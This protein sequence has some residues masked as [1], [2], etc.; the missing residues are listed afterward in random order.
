M[1]DHPFFVKE[2]IVLNTA[3]NH[4]N[5]DI[6]RA[7]ALIAHA[8]PVAA[9]I[10]KD[11]ILRGAWMMA[12]GALDA[13]F[14]DAYADLVARTLRAKAIQ[15]AVEIPDRLNKL[16]LPV[17][18]ILHPNDSW[19]WRMAAR[20]LI[21]EEN[22]LSLEQIRKLFNH[23]FHEDRKLMNQETI[24]GWVT[25]ADA[26][27]RLFGVTRTAYNALNAAQKAAARKAALKQ[28]E[29]RYKSIFQRR[30]DCIHNCDRPL[31]APQQVAP[32]MVTK[33]KEDVSFLVAR[34]HQALVAEFPVYLQTL[35]FNAVTRNQVTQ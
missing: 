19:R 30:H 28:F 25:H 34:C 13:Y 15:P 14:S 6:L 23:F 5:A 35:G 26:R 11:D 10:L 9:G 33:V 29:A 4:F 20:E 8:T 17:M 32:L 31:V 21:E 7:E 24:E 18:A 22:V 12:V 3:R 1:A 16:K 27:Q 2:G